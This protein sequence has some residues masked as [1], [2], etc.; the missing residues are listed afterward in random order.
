MRGVRYGAT[1][2][3]PSLRRRSEYGLFAVA[4]MTN[5]EKDVVIEKDAREQE[6]QE[7]PLLLRIGVFLVTEI[8]RLFSNFGR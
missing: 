6:Q 7:E 8:L 3:Y 4:R 2:S 5:R 1:W